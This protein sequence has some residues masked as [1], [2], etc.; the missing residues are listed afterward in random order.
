MDYQIRKAQEGDLPVIRALYGRAREF[1]ARSGNPDQWGSTYPEEEIF[2]GDMREGN[3]FLLENETGIH[4]VFLFRI[5]E[6]PTYQIIEKGS[7]H[8]DKP[9]GVIHR[10][11][12]D[13]SGGILKAAVEFAQGQISYLRIDTHE[14]NLPMQRSI[15][16]QGFQRCGV[17]YTR[18]GSPRI[19]YD[20]ERIL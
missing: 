18:S 19:A 5:F 16:K 9:Y 1:M 7:W 11:A 20:R 4:G 3:L 6:D 17:I 15:L 14:K 10:V 12:G 2:A 13:G 8:G